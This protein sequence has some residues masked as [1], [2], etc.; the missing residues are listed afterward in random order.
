LRQV[1]NSYAVRPAAVG[2]YYGLD[3]LVRWREVA[4]LVPNLAW[5]TMIILA[6]LA[7]SL[8]TLVR[9]RN[10]YNEAVSRK[11]R[12][13][14]KVAQVRQENQSLRRQTDELKRD[15]KVGRLAAEQRLRL[16]GRNEAVIAV[17]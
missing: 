6:I 9:S 5:L 16:V 13:A 14:D 11:A 10:A 4:A 8:S 7:L 2:D 12:T 1:V 17:R 3:L 15:P